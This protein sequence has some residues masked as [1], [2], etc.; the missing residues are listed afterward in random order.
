MR[1]GPTI[2]QRG[3]DRVHR[4]SEFNPLVE[5]VDALLK[6][7]HQQQQEKATVPAAPAIAAQ[8]A[9]QAVPDGDDDI[10]VLTEIIDAESI[11]ETSPA[12]HGKEFAAGI[13]NAVLEKLLAELDRALELRL[14]RTIGE[15]LEQVLDGLRAELSASIR[16]MVRE[17]VATAVAKEIAGRERSS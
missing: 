16:E 14:N 17:A 13:E 1:S 15:L 10:P 5:R 11:G 8:S 6:R 3:I 7:H 2:L 12:L 4:M 9:P